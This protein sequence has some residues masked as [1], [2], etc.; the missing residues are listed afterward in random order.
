MNDRS[1]LENEDAAGIEPK[2]PNVG[3]SYGSEF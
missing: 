2:S 1:D 3:G